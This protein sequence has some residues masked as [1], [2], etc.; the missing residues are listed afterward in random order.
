MFIVVTDIYIIQDMILLWCA[1][2]LLTSLCLHTGREDY[3]KTLTAAD[4]VPLT[5]EVVQDVC[6]YNCVLNGLY[7]EYIKSIV[8]DTIGT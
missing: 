6:A 7:I 4:A 5:I 1:N 2:Y 3:I 8:I